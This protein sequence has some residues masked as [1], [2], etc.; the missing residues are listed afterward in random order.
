MFVILLTVNMKVEIKL[1]LSHCRC[2]MLCSPK[3]NLGWISRLFAVISPRLLRRA[4]DGWEKYVIDL[5]LASF[6]GILLFDMKHAS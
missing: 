1:Y 3:W 5:D 6:S 4:A 2:A